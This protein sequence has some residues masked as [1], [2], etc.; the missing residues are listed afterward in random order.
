LPGKESL[1]V[2][3][4]ACQKAIIGLPINKTKRDRLFESGS[5]RWHIRI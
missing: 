2:F 5:C 4:V 1:A 3:F